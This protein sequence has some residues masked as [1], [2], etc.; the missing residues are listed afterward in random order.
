MQKAQA[1][2]SRSWE[3]CRT[4][5]SAGNAASCRVRNTGCLQPTLHIDSPAGGCPDKTRP[6]FHLQIFR[7]VTV[8]STYIFP[9][10]PRRE[11]CLFCPK[12]TWTIRTR[13]SIWTSACVCC[14][15]VHALPGTTNTRNH[16]A[17]VRSY[18][19]NQNCHGNR[20]HAARKL[21]LVAT[22]KK[23]RGPV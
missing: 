15:S 16:G 10:C 18:K 23:E 11:Q 7:L 12:F 5:R 3:Q 13:S 1:E 9:F 2:E 14:N 20:K 21:H 8:G 19:R 17:K 22:Q 6:K 4:H